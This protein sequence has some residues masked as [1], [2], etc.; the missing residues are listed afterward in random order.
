MIILYAVPISLWPKLG[1][2]N[3]DFYSRHP[4][5]NDRWFYITYTNYVASFNMYCQHLFTMGPVDNVSAL[6]FRCLFNDFI[7]FYI[8]R[9]N[10][11]VLRP[12]EKL[13]KILPSTFIYES[14]LVKIDMNAN[15]MKTQ[16]FYYKRRFFYMSQKIYGTV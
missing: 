8:S 15:N 1:K 13:S 12:S 2:E 16:L 6:L 10:S 7:Q 4:Y 9:K 11:F 3:R 14:I 5:N